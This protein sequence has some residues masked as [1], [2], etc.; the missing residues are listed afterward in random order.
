MG[1]AKTS[2]DIADDGAMWTLK[3]AVAVRNLMIA[4]GDGAKSLWFIE[5]SWSKHTNP[6]NAPNWVLGVSE[7]TQSA[8]FTATIN[9]VRSTMP[10]VGK[11]YWYT[12]RD[13]AAD[14]TV[15]NSN[16]GLLRLDGSA[17]PLHP[18]PRRRHVLGQPGIR[19]DGTVTAVGRSTAAAGSGR[20]RLA[21]HRYDDAAHRYDDAAHRFLAIAARR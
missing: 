7:A 19:R 21:D 8:F 5:F 14:G 20:D 6:A 15:Q 17:K 9:L 2:A 10:Y 1:M 13:S 4:H 11:V 3:H 16:Y 12:E 18:V